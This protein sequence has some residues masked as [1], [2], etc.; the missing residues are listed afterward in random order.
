MDTEYLAVDD[1]S[2]DHEVEDL[3]TGFPDRCVAILLHA[4]FI[5]PIDLG[6]LARFMVATDKCDFVGVSAQK[7]VSVRS[8]PK[9]HGGRT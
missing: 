9:E 2:E 8:I 1:G 7:Y 4:F 5:K 6:N 3:T